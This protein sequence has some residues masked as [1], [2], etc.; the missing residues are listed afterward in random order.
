MRFLDCP[1]TPATPR[2]TVAS[3]TLG[4]FHQATLAALDAVTHPIG[5]YAKMTV[6]T[7]AYA[8]SG[9]VVKIQA[10]LGACAEHIEDD[11]PGKLRWA[12][13]HDAEYAQ[14]FFFWPRKCSERHFK[15]S[16]CISHG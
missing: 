14:H 9:D 6:E 8:L 1:S 7:C 10:L 2:D 11:L 12:L 3:R 16:A 15:V 4:A 5:K 13:E